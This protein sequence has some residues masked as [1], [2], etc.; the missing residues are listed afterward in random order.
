MHAPHSHT[1]WQA[2]EKRYIHAPHGSKLITLDGKSY[3]G[4]STYKYRLVIRDDRLLDLPHFKLDGKLYEKQL[5][6]GILHAHMLDGKACYCFSLFQ[7][8]LTLGFV[9]CR[10]TLFKRGDV[11]SVT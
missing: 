10:L 4:N 8:L 6:T 3:S 7:L 1:E 5:K 9:R 11:S 2:E